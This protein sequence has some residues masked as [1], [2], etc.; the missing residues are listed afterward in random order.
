MCVGLG[1]TVPFECRQ[2]H[3][4][5]KI[6]RVSAPAEGGASYLLVWLSLRKV[7]SAR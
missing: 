5:Y 6:D 2:G 3:L 7:R 1:L 4:V